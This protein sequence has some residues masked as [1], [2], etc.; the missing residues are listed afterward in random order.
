MQIQTRPLHV[1]TLLASISLSGCGTGEASAV[2][3]NEPLSND[4]PIPVEISLPSRGEISATHAVSA[5][6]ASDIDAPVTAR[7]AGE[8]VEI[9]VEEGDWVESGQILARLDG[10]RLRLEMLEAKAN[11]ERAQK[12]FERNVDLHARG[13]ISTSM[14]DGLKF[15]LDALQA[16]YRLKQLNYGYSNI[17][18]TIPGVVSAREIKR[19]VSLASGDVT[20][21]I[22][23]VSELIAYLQI[24]QAELPKFSVGH[25][26]TV[27]VASMPAQRFNATVIR[28]SP[29]IDMNSGTF[30]ATVLIDNEA[31]HIAPGMFGQFRISYEKHSDALLI[32]AAA[33]IE[34][35]ND[36]TVYVVTDGTVESRAVRIGFEQ[37]GRVEILHGLQEDEEIVVVGHASLKNGS[38]I[39]A[40]AATETRFTG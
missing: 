20:F 13:L 32:P 17:R 25:T 4:V 36:M 34:E 11:L 3:S 35:D 16:S 18:A 33:L 2:A 5:T 23:D 24:P 7:V 9:L 15:D 27:S 14:F 8:V 19:G 37:D 21:R 40:S 12:E 1:L 22:T 30:R 29:T 28:L 38:R 31:G 6:I 10:E 26:A 39:L